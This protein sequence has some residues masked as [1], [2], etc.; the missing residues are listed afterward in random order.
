MHRRPAY[1]LAIAAL[2]SLALVACTSVGDLLSN[3]V[4]VSPEQLQSQL[5]R[6]FPRDYRKLGGMVS[7]RVM[8]P[9]LH[10]QPERH[11]LLLDFDAGVAAFGSD[12]ATPRG[13]FTVS[14]G[15]RFDPAAMALMLDAPAVER[16]DVPALAG[17]GQGAIESLL[18][19]W[20][21]DEARNEPV[22]RFST[23]DQDKLR[24]RSIRGI[25]VTASGLQVQLGNG[26]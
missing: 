5:D 21:L 17:F 20:L 4:T 22:Y 18:N 12:P 14:S 15:L 25:A 1:R 7:V 2:L 9:R 8:H 13:H 10:L 16:A 6:R 24:G 19:Q 11:R 26:Q 3:R 23:T